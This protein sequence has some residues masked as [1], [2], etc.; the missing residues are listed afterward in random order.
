M[1]WRLIAQLGSPAERVEAVHNH[2]SGRTSSE[3]GSVIL[4]TMI[5]AVLLCGVLVLLNRLQRERLRR[6]EQEHARRL[7]EL[8]KRPRQPEF[9]TR[10][11]RQ[12]RSPAGRQH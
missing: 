2:F 6:E 9:L 4:S 10:Q 11:R 8:A 3:M 1:L 12:L 7:R 5:I